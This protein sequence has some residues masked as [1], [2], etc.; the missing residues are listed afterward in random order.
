MQ[1][2][3]KTKLS[4]PDQSYR[5]L[6]ETKTRQNNDVTD[7]IGLVYVKTETELLRPI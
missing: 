2:T 3:L 5:E 4:F 1:F 6:T 7:H